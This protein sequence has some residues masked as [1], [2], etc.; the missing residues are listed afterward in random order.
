MAFENLGL[1]SWVWL[2]PSWDVPIPRTCGAAAGLQASRIWGSGLALAP[3]S[4]TFLFLFSSLS[5]GPRASWMQE[6][7]WLCQEQGGRFFSVS[8]DNDQSWGPAS[9]KE[10]PGRVKPVSSTLCPALGPRA[11]SPASLASVLTLIASLIREGHLWNGNIY[12][13]GVL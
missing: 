3:A 6:K 12:L 2:T 11:L 7:P 8:Q 9:P 1:R 5:T 4:V 13:M 10:N